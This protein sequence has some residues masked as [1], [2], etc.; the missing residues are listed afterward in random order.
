MELAAET[1]RPR[2]EHC[3]ILRYYPRLPQ[4]RKCPKRAVPQGALLQFL[5]ARA[6]TLPQY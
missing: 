4:A 3:T 1:S 2:P 5:G 6:I